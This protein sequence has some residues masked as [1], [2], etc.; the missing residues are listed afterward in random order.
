MLMIVMI[1]TMMMNNKGH[2]ANDVTGDDGSD[3]GD[4]NVGNSCTAEQFCILR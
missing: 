1:K 4:G 3:D 2:N